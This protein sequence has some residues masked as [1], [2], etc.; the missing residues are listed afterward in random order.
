MKLMNPNFREQIP[1]MSDEQIVDVLKN[2][3]HYQQEASSFAI[4]EAVKR[5]IIHSEQDLFSER[6]R[7]SPVRRSL[8]PLI[9]SDRIR[10]KIT[11]SILRAFL[12]SGSIPLIWSV[13]LLIRQ[14]L[15]EGLILLMLSLLWIGTCIQLWRNRSANLTGVLIV[16]LI[17]GV[18]YVSNQLLQR[19]GLP[20]M[21]YFIHV[22][23]F[24]F[25]LYGILYLRH[26]I[27]Q[28]K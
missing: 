14:S 18:V 13:L 6:F 25:L 20:F 17:G 19:K 10:L 16:L 7:P 27:K 26:L 5:G 15:A 24:A 9:E 3:E 12:L 8:F 28:G 21:D 11:K 4:E 22:V 2:R 1:Q 23:V